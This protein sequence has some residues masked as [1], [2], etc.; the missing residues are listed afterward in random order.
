MDVAAPPLPSPRSRILP[1]IVACALFMENLDSTIITTALPAIARDM[2]EDPLHLSLAITSYLL[3]LT[4]FIPLSGWLAD[5]Y[6]AR[7]V[8]RNAILIFVL[9]SLACAASQGI[10]GLVA[11]RMLQG[12]GGAMMVP[13]GR[14]VL[15][16][17]I[18]KSELVSAMTYVT[19]P[20]LMAP[21]FGPPVGGLIVTYA[22][23]QWIFIVNVPIGVLGWV[24][25]SR[26]VQDARQ[27]L[28][29]PLDLAGWWMLGGGMAGLVFGMESLGKH[30][31]SPGA[32]ALSLCVGALLMI[33]Y[34]RHARVDEA[35]LLRISLL[36]IASFRAS[37]T[38]GSLFRVG[39]GASTLLLPMML[40]LG[41]GLSALH[42]GLLTFATAAGALAMKTVAPRLTRRFG[43]RRI[44]VHNTALCSI[45]LAISGWL[46][47]N[48]PLALAL[49]FLLLTGFLRS[50]QFT[51]VNA[52]AF[53]DV[54]E[55]DMS[56]AS[57]ASSTVQQ[58]ALSVGVGI[59]SQVLNLSMALRGGQTLV[60]SDF[61]M[62]FCA[63]ALLSLLGVI[64]FRAMAED[65]GESVSGHRLA[66]A[67]GPAAT[68]AD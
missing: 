10:G 39:V 40:Q 17:Q 8:F 42:S 9:G 15:L 35:P 22:A 60:A 3:S 49:G 36:K 26:Y 5:R 28:R 4:I 59:G 65:A 67:N 24:L 50:L 37:V 54:S 43:F 61:T 53:A 2:G 33:L 32:T 56:Q 34:V 55:R 45:G 29:S 62:A 31:V 12:L 1:L 21:I 23:W 14:L 25:V 6:G 51:C 27:D 11:A 7:T 68:A 46:S 16:R 47:P 41:Y 20:A 58:L 18:P 52:L 57:S 38:G 63:M 19:I 13:V 44:L 66:L 64:S 48:W 30:V